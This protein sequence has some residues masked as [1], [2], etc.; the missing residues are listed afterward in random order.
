MNR[1]SIFLLCTA[2]LCPASSLVWADAQGTVLLQ[3]DFNREESNPEKEDVGGGWT[4]NSKARAKGN[5]QVDLVD[6]AVHITMHEDADHGV[7]LVHDVAFQ[8]ATITCR[9]K[10]G[11][12]NDVGFNI[13][14]MKEKSVHAGHICMAR[15]KPGMLQISDL[16]TGNMNQEIYEARKAGTITAE[17]KQMAKSKNKNFKIKLATDQWHDLSIA[18]L[19]DTMTVKIDGEEVGEFSSP[20]IAHPTKSRLRIA[21]NSDAWVDDLK[22]VSGI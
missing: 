2:I 6:G 3:D 12:K 20:G 17:Q 14:D 5:K 11:K 1:T 19:G 18:I 13:A 21:V 16:K 8:D 15:I 10:I 4:T 9:F 22:I 7:S